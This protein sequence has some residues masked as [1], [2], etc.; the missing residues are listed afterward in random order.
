MFSNLER[1]TADQLIEGATVRAYRKNQIVFS[2]GD[3]AEGFFIVAEGGV[4]LFRLERDG[5]EATINI[6]HRPQSFGEAAFFLERTYPV[7]AQTIAAS[8]LIRVDAAVLIERIKADPALA[9]DLLS[10][11]SAHLRLLV[12]EITLLR[13][14]TALRR[15]AELLLRSCPVTDGPAEFDLPHNKTILAKRLDISPAVL[16]RTLAE[17]RHSGITVTR[18]TVTIKDVSVLYLLARTER[19]AQTC[20]SSI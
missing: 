19:F 17:L 12:D 14:P 8:R 18:R 20:K 3:K 4:R 5:S 7:M 15:A 9:L 1:L 16:S 13:V 10:S 11:M 6:F 2:A